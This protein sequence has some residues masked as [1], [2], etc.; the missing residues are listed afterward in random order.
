MAEP[1]TILNG[2]ASTETENQTAESFYD[3]GQDNKI[4]ELTRKTEALEKE[5]REMKERIKKL[6]IEIEGSE[7]DKRVFE[8]IAAR[9][10]E[11]ETEVS[12]LQHDLIT[13]MSEGD[14]A[15]AEV[16]EL[17]K[18]LGEKGVK[19]EGLEKEIDGLKSEK[20]DS[21]KKVRELERKVGTLEVRELEEKSKRVRVEEEM[22]EKIDDKEREIS[23]FKKKVN[24][25]ESELDKWTVE[26]KSVE[27]SLKESESK[28]KEME[29]KISELEKE[30][31]E[32]KTVISGLK[33]ETLDGFNGNVRDFKPSVDDGW[34]KSNLQWSV[35]AATTSV[36]AVAVIGVCCARRR[37]E[38]SGNCL[39]QGNFC[40]DHINQS[41]RFSALEVA[42]AAIYDGSYYQTTNANTS[43]KGQFV[44]CAGQLG[45]CKTLSFNMWGV[46]DVQ[47]AIVLVKFLHLSSLNGPWVVLEL[48]SGLWKASDVF[49]QFYWFL[50]FCSI[51]FRPCASDSYVPFVQ[52]QNLKN[53]IIS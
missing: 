9:A 29:A 5:N 43:V 4:A 28:S 7:E 26:K 13:A 33:E 22:R 1:E 38:F 47:E 18:S 24:D 37:H 8:S 15:N 44:N 36:V 52:K 35:V 45:Y 51:N 11:L 20:A 42:G 6:T 16:A 17:K 46:M 21:E 19:L 41:G 48:I 2:V 12:R 27:E 10:V 14:E 31:D 30:I 32:A 39:I 40:I 25:L 50:N 34:K 23:G 49:V 53:T 3:L